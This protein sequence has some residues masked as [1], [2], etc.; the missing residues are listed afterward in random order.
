MFMKHMAPNLFKGGFDLPANLTCK[1]NRGLLWI[2]IS[3]RGR[4]ADRSPLIDMNTEKRKLKCV[5][6]YLIPVPFVSRNNI[7]SPIDKPVNTIHL[8]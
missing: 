7:E 5:T 3:N 2:F 6:E 4:W 1:H 8:G